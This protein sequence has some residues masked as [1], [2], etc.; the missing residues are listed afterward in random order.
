ML[1]SNMR[2]AIHSDRILSHTLKVGSSVVYLQA[3]FCRSVTFVLTQMIKGKNILLTWSQNHMENK[4][5]NI[6]KNIFKLRIYS[7]QGKKRV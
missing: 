6:I 3:A 2:E 4:N 1:I 5:F 7:A